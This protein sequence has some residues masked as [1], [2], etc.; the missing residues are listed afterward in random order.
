MSKINLFLDSSALFA[1]IAS[2]TGAARALLLL[3]ETEI[4]QITISEQVVAETERAIGRKVPKALN[5]LRMAIKAS[6]A[7]IVRDPSIEEVVN[8]L[9]LITHAADVPIVLAAMKAKVNF[10]VTLNRRHFMNDP[11]VAER[12]GLKIFT[13]GEALAQ[14]RRQISIEHLEEKK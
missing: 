5:D 6:K 1:G 4:I 11:R 9:E 3:A 14:V 2:E 13:P 8:H 10:L 7:R 12:S